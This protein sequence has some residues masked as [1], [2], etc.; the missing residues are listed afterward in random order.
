MGKTTGFKEFT[1]KS[2]AY[3]PAAER[4]KDFHELRVMPS[5][6]HLSNQT[7]RCMDCGVPFC[8]SN[9]GCPLGNLIPEWNHLVYSGR[10]KEAS[11]RLHATN[12]FPEFTGR[13][14]PAPCETACVLGVVD[15]PVTIRDIE[16]VIADRAWES[17]WLTPPRTPRPNGKRVAIVGSG[18]A[19]LAAAQQLARQGYA[20]TV[21]ERDD[22]LGGLLMYGIPNMKLDKSVVE[23]RLGQLRAEGVRFE[24][25]VEVGKDLSA[26]ELLSKNDAVLLAIGAAKPRDLVIEG[27][28]LSGIHFAMEY[29]TASTKSLL[30]GTPTPIDAKGKDVLVIGGGDTGTDC[31]GTALR[32]GC[33][34]LVNFELMP[35]PLDERLPD[36]PWP[37]WPKVFRIEYGHAEAAKIFGQ[38][39]RY[40]QVQATRFLGIKGKVKGVATVQVKGPSMAMV[41][42]TEQT[43][44]TDLV[45]LAMGF[46]GPEQALIEGLT[47]A[48]GAGSN[49]SAPNYQ[50]NI[51]GVFAAGDCRRGQSLVVWAIDEGRRAA[52][53]VHQYCAGLKSAE[54]A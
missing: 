6:D 11:E 31:I 12:N 16:Q 29:L 48:T 23:R 19:G 53:A 17:G 2:I 13:V 18:P 30:A 8:T 45:L 34:S 15:L 41:A 10:W 26:D 1:R 49:I 36:N 51:P 22:R 27:R 54:I 9:D 43:W 35:K 24:T 5:D 7:A 14:C 46:V 28:E 37:Q 50:T 4:V 21:Y 52:A 40:F 42:G 32:Q 39:P 3:R 20:V 25:G 47:L 44:K 33:K 38:D